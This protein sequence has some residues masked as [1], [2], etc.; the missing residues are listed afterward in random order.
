MQAAR[1][2]RCCA[3]HPR[4]APVQGRGAAAVEEARRSSPL[5]DEVAAARCSPHFMIDFDE[6]QAIG[7]RYRRQDE[8]GTPL[9]RH[10]RLRLARRP[11]PSPS[12]TATRWS[13]SGCRS[14]GSSTTCAPAWPSSRP[15]SRFGCGY[16]GAGA[17]RF[18]PKTRDCGVGSGVAGEAEA[19]ERP[20]RARR[21][22][23]AVG[24]PGVAGRGDAAAAAQHL[25]VHH[26]L[27]VVL[28]DRAGGRVRS[29]GRASRGWP[30]TA[31]PRRTLAQPASLGRGWV[32]PVELAGAAAPGAML[33][34][35]LG[36]QPGARPAG[37][38]IGLVLAHVARR[39]RSGRPARRP[40]RVNTD[41]PSPSGSQ[42]SGASQP[43]AWTV[44]QP[45][46]IH[47][48]GRAYPPSAMNASQ[49]PAVT[50]RSASSN[51]S[52]QRVVAG[53]LVVEAKPSAVRARCRPRRPSTLRPA[54]ELAS[55]PGCRP[56]CAG[57]VG[58]AAAG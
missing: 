24:A 7:R 25:L 3:S 21:E 27:A 49:S 1:R 52:E 4:L 50:R 41:Q 26:E 45:S 20:A 38:G 42:Y 13:R 31:T 48:S 44:A 40:P 18:P 5:A 55:A 39:A 37:E 10:R 32:Q 57:A 29:P 12:A 16:R 34:L 15:T 46:D 6:T 54:Q 2:A 35:G 36:R 51:G 8:L 47:S 53:P 11:T 23:V 14:T 28:A 56:A 30:S 19:G 17:R 33:P 22:E 43:S 9:L 58:R